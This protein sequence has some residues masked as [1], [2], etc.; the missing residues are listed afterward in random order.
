M[1]KTSSLTCLKNDVTESALESF[2]N[3]KSSRE[4][5]KSSKSHFILEFASEQQKCKD[6]S[7]TQYIEF[8]FRTRHNHQYIDSIRQYNQLLPF[9]NHSLTR[10][11][12]CLPV[13]V[14]MSQFL[15]HVMEVTC[16]WTCCHKLFAC[17]FVRLRISILPVASH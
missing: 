9:R 7:R 13:C 15:G 10:N 3:E 4:H 8:M 14:N 11:I 6:Q 1:L 17:K 5:F 2:C 12:L 16:N